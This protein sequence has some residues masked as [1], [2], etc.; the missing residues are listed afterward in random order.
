[1][2]LVALIIFV[3]IQ[4]LMKINGAG[5]YQTYVDPT[6]TSIDYNTTGIALI[7]WGAIMLGVGA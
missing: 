3:V 5:L 1:M 4:I 6:N 2:I 7:A